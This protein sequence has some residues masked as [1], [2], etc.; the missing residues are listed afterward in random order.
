MNKA[1]SIKQQKIAGTYYRNRM[2]RYLV[3]RGVSHAVMA[4]DRDLSPAR[5][6]QIVNRQK[7]SRLIRFIHFLG[8][9]MKS[10]AN[11]RRGK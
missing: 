9:I 6:S 1:E 5:I 11:D 2:I 4:K 10:L 3:K 7:P 8:D